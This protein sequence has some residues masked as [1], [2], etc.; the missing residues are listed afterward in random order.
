MMSTEDHRKGLI[1]MKN[2]N[3]TPF[4]TKRKLKHGSVAIALTVVFIAAIILFNAVFSMLATRYNWYADM[5]EEQVYGM[6]EAGQ[7]LLSSLAGSGKEYDIIFCCD[8]DELDAVYTGRIVHSFV[9]EMKSRC[10]F[11]NVEYYDI[12]TSPHLVDRFKTTTTSE[13]SP[14]SVIV[15][16]DTDFRIFAFESFFYTNDQGVLWAFQGELKLLTALIQL[17]DENPIAY[18]TVGHAETTD[19]SG[20]WNLF[21]TAGYEVRTIDLSKEYPADQAQVMIING[22]KYDFVGEQADS[23]DAN[24][25]KKIDDFLDGFGHL[26]VFID[27]TA[28]KLTELEDYLYEWGIVFTDT[29]VKDYENAISTDGT[30]LVASY[31]TEGL[32]ATAHENIRKLKNPPKTIVRE[33][34]ALELWFDV[35][36]SRSTS[37]ILT[38]APSSV[39]L[40]TN[41]GEQI[42]TGSKNLMVI[43][44][45]EEYIDN[46][47]YVSY[48]TAAGTTH[49]ADSAYLFSNAYGNGDI[50]F[51]LMKAMG[52]EQVPIDI[53]F[54]VF[55]DNS[56]DITT[57]EANNWTVFLIVFAP[58]VVLICGV[59]VFFRRKHL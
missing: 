34:S 23:E 51:T 45:R 15:A 59:V 41:S 49:F 4:L 22:P 56:L 35:R 21:Q 32:G 37:V 52:K 54:K 48:V 24:E 14:A 46:F 3:T 19:T 6:S 47:S 57:T 43:S 25:I 26:M 17:S 50:L 30:A 39:T 28:Q 53:D 8:P 13:I 12:L 55:E 18:F 16:S 1:H 29:I 42:G 31:T 27:P 58:I 36:N 38:S 33:A 44:S 40:D 5:T 7:L 20:L 9:K 11:L 2:K 10:D